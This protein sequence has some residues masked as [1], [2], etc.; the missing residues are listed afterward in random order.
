MAG[1]Q[2]IHIESYARFGSERKDPKS[3][4]IN[5]KWS[6]RDIVAEARR[7]QG[8][9]SHIENPQ[10][11][12]SGLVYGM[13]LLELEKIAHA[14]GDNSKDKTGKKLRKDGHCLLAG[15]ISLPDSEKGD[16]EKFKAKSVEWLKKN[17]GDRLKTVVEHLDESHPHIH[18][19]CV[20]RPG[21]TFE[22][23]HEGQAA[24]KKAAAQ[25]KVKGEQ[26]QA[27]IEAMR[28]FQD[29]FANVAQRFG[30]ARLGPGRR[31]LTREQWKSEQIQAEA[32]KRAREKANRIY[33]DAKKK[34]I[35]DSKTVG[36][37]DKMKLSWHQPSNE[38]KKENEELKR[39]NKE[40][41]QEKEELKEK[42]RSSIAR[43]LDEIRKSEK[44]KEELQE[45]KNQKRT[46]EDELKEK[47]KKL[48]D[49]YH[50]QQQQEKRQDQPNKRFSI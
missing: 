2:F 4:K 38:L 26:N 50:K 44:L 6:I 19:Y 29:A 36:F 43:A 9:I 11:I 40:L 35:E 30:L 13:P 7:E 12:D 32:L 34:G 27:Y 31:R 39:K 37:L 23:I 48:L 18:F 33:K 45:N 21:E 8:A 25:G 16:W 47:N 28:G 42:S 3:G 46:M 24:A 49:I 5:K 1:Y 14:W 10:E 41:E 17:Y 20:P 22:T 15:V